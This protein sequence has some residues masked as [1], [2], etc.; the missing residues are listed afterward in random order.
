ML[1]TSTRL[2]RLLSVLQSRRFWTGAG[3]AERL[4]ITARTLRRDVDRLRSLGYTVLAT[5]GPGGGYQLGRGAVLPPL[6]L[7]DA[8]AVAIAVSLRSGMD[9][10]SGINETVVRTLAKLQQLL[11]P[12][13]HARISA[14]NAATVSLAGPGERVNPEVLIALANACRDGRSATLQ[15]RDRM[16]RPSARLIEPLRLAY[17]GNRRWYLVAYDLNRNAWRTFRVDRIDGIPVLGAPFNPRPPP[18]DLKRYVSNAIASAPYRFRAKF[19]LNGSMTIVAPSAPPWVGVLEPL[20]ET[21]CMLSTGADSP[22]AL[23]LQVML[24]GVDFDLIEPADLRPSLIKIAAR[25]RRAAQR[26]RASSLSPR[27][28]RIARSR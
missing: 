7:D 6:L 24:C 15:Y 2:L 19:R 20:D 1:D 23:V 27:I 26:D 4:G 28:G 22:E 16:D 10:Y 13:L 9:A 18:A 21:H 5:A 3:L 12:R 17:T 11:P 25:L 8:E 14:L